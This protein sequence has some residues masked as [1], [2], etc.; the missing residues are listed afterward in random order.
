MAGLAVITGASSGI[1]RALARRCAEHGFDLVVAADEGLIKAA[2]RELRAAG[3][4]HVT[5]V[6]TD[7]ATREGVEELHAAVVATE[8]PVEALLLNA[9]VGTGGAFTDVPLADDLRVVD[10]NVRSTVHLAKLLVPGMVER[11]QGRVLVTASI[12]AGL[13]GVF[14]STY[15][16]SKAFDLSFALALREELRDSG[17]TVTAL[18]PGPTDTPFFARN[19]MDDTRIATGP[20]DDPE[21]VA[22]AGFKGMLEGEERVV[23]SSLLT[24]VEHLGARFLPD[25]AKASLHRIMSAPGSG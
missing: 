7:L 24:K 16:A 15:N 19:A 20:K 1:G 3:A 21:D 10:V 14:Q 23:A 25:G 11:G 2:A 9:G 17:V 18:L 13:P 5:A 12:A 8:R 22:D 4:D 6:R